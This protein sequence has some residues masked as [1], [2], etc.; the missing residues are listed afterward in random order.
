[1]EGGEGKEGSSLLDP[2]R[3]DE[4]IKDARAFGRIDLVKKSEHRGPLPSAFAVTSFVVDG[5]LLPTTS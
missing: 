3:V 5:H 4:E 1:M 2:A